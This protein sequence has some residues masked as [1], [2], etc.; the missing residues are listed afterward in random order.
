MQRAARL[1]LIP[2]LSVA[3]ALPARSAHATP[4]SRLFE[5]DFDRT[6]AAALA[7]FEQSNIPVGTAEKSQGL[8]R[9]YVEFTPQNANEW[10]DHNTTQRVRAL[11]GWLN[12]Q[13]GVTVTVVR[14]S[15]QVTEVSIEPSIKAYNVWTEIWRNLDSSGATENSFFESLQ[16]L[17]VLQKTPGSATSG[18]QGTLDISSRPANADIEIDG[19]FVGQT[20]AKLNLA[21][22]KHAIHVK[23]GGY[24]AWQRDLEIL[25]G[26]AT[27]LEAQLTKP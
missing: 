21:P 25:P 12:V 1:A 13:V 24:S 7:S 18:P 26:A 19:K 3:L 22:G 15:D 5:A 23:K 17:L 16:N 27:S 11:S 8:I 9:A 6:W 14:R 4:K 20:P 10:V 2:L